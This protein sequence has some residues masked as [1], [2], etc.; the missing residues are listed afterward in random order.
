MCF[1]SGLFSQEGPFYS[2][3]VLPLSGL[4]FFYFFCLF[5]FLLVFVFSSFQ[6]HSL[7]LFCL[8]FACGILFPS[9]CGLVGEILAVPFLFHFVVRPSAASAALSDILS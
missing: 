7:F 6:P 4:F 3:T 9:L 8:P 2:L 5:C 1:L